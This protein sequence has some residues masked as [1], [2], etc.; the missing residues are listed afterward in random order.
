[1]EQN[2][3]ALLVF[4]NQSY[5]LILNETDS[6][7]ATM[8]T[9]DALLTQLQVNM[10]ALDLTLIKSINGQ[11]PINHQLLVSAGSYMKVTDYPLVGQVE[12]GSLGI[13]TLN[14]VNLNRAANIVAGAGISVVNTPPNLIN[15]SNTIADLFAT[16]CVI[17]VTTNPAVS[18]LSMQ[19]NVRN[20][21]GW[22]AFN[23][24]V[25]SYPS[26]PQPF[27]SS[28]DSFWNPF[29]PCLNYYYSHYF[30]QPA[31]MWQLRLTIGYTMGQIQNCPTPT[32]CS[33]TWAVGMLDTVTGDFQY[34]DSTYINI[35]QGFT[36]NSGYYQGQMFMNGY[37]IPVGRTFKFFAWYG[38]NSPVFYLTVFST[39]LVATRVG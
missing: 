15:V 14:G 26:C 3:T 19:L 32:G 8:I 37:N 28:Q 1:L 39:Q 29:C 9:L 25:K 17:T 10:T 4:L 31:G 16:P 27:S 38:S 24:P 6:I 2:I 22:V 21:D 23:T 36:T 5:Y 20:E 11:L 34:F 18:P 12:L 33:L 35:G 7:N 30:T 13:V